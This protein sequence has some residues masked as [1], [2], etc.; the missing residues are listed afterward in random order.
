[1]TSDYISA[2]KM[3]DGSIDIYLPNNGS[4]EYV[5]LCDEISLG[6]NDPL[7]GEILANESMPLSGEF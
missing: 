2:E 4:Y 6:K 3:A 1:M 5:S 7:Q